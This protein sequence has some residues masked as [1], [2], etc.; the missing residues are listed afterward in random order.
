VE[1]AR[2]LIGEAVFISQIRR[3]VSAL[4]YTTEEGYHERARNALVAADVLWNGGHHA[5]V[6]ACA[7]V[8][9]AERLAEAGTG[10]SE[11]MPEILLNLVKALEVLFGGS[12]D[13]IREGLAALGYSEAEREGVFIPLVLLRHDMDVGHAKLS[14]YSRGVLDE[15]YGFVLD[16]PLAIKELVVRAINATIAGAWT[17]PVPSEPATEAVMKGLLDSIGAGTEARR[18]RVGNRP[19]LVF[20]YGVAKPT[21][22]TPAT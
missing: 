9:A 2:V 1:S 8:H 11:F 7:Y 5:L 12:R 3:A 19:Y 6:A 16:A 14:S 18:Q 20:E 21:L 15:V 17:P 22:V 4:E 10:P 13:R